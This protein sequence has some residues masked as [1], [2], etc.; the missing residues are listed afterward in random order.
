[1]RSDYFQRDGRRLPD[2]RQFISRRTPNPDGSLDMRFNPGNVG[3]TVFATALQGDGKLL[4]GGNFRQAAAV[5][6]NS[7]VR[8]NGELLATWPAGD[9]GPRNI[10]LP[11]VDD[12]LDESDETLRLEL[13]PVAGGAKAG[14]PTTLT[15]TIQDND[16]RPGAIGPAPGAAT[17]GAAYRHVLTA[18]GAPAPAFSVTSG[19]L[20]PGISLSADGTLEGTPTATGTFGPIV[21][22]AA[23]GVEVAGDAGIHAGGA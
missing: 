1:M 19:S 23:N 3:G 10:S 14:S 15:L 5:A 13:Q 6:R 16:E 11:I 4:V 12:A 17:F 7:I 22:Q 20:P 21:V 8:F 18:A 9:S 2:G